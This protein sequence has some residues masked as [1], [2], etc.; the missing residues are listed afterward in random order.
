MNFLSFWGE[1]LNTLNWENNWK[2]LQ[3]M[4]RRQYQL[5]NSQ[6][7]FKKGKFHK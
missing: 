5:N 6:E 2:I 7:D 1:K 4:P 3:L